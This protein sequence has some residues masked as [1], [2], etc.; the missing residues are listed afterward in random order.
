MRRTS[1]ALVCFSH[2]AA[3]G[4]RQRHAHSQGAAVVAEAV[5][6]WIAGVGAKTAFIAMVSPCENGNVESF[7]GK[8]RDE[9]LN[10]AIFCTLKEAQMLIEAWRHHDLGTEH[11]PKSQGADLIPFD[12]FSGVISDM[13][14]YRSAQATIRQHG[15]RAALKAAS[16]LPIWHFFRNTSRY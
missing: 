7:N 5:R 3:P 12:Q 6:S 10:G 16:P 4:E 8:P 9:L 13:N 14:I 15:D 11:D 2:P 1:I